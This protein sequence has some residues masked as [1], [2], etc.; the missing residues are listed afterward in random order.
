MT[1]TPKTYRD[2]LSKDFSTKRKDTNEKIK[3]IQENPDFLEAH[4]E[5]AIKV[6]KDK[7]Y[8]ELDDTR[9]TEEYQG[10]KSKKQALRGKK[11]DV[12]KQEEIV[13]EQ[14]KLLGDKEAELAT[15]SEEYGEKFEKKTEKK[16]SNEITKEH[17]LNKPNMTA[18]DKEWMQKSIDYL[19]EKKMDTSENLQKLDAI[20]Y[21]QESIEIW[22][23]KRARKD[24]SAKPNGKNIFQHNN[25][26]YFKRS[27]N[28]IKEQNDLLAKQNME[29]PLNSA[30]EKSMKALP[31]NY[32]KSNR[33]E[34]WNI[35]ALITN[36]SMDG[37]C[38]SDGKLNNKGEYGSRWS[39]S[40]EGLSNARNFSFLGDE[41]IL[42]RH[43]RNN[44]LP[45]RP[46]LK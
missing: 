45:V 7:L 3:R 14:K 4:K 21:T 22:G 20:V 26:T 5:E 15:M 28:M 10:A 6:V 37:Y 38:D 30:Y 42:D 13:A 33:Y 23:V 27:E 44:A 9:A 29:I 46:V 11:K 8:K 2:G 18:K 40:S 35:L 25:V 43:N 36:M 16:E 17:L 39:A 31:G 41:G 34:W 12:K 32:S 1:K 24:I 19:V